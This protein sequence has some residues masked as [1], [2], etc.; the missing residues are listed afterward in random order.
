VPGITALS[1]WRI[2]GTPVGPTALMGFAVAICGVR[3][4]IVSHE[5]QAG[6]P[7]AADYRAGCGLERKVAKVY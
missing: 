4:A 1:A 3:L 5:R 6:D 7:D 2:L